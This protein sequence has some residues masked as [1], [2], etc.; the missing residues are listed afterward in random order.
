MLGKSLPFRFYL[1]TDRRLFGP[2]PIEARLETLFCALPAGTLAVQVREKDLATRDLLDLVRRIRGVAVP[3]GVPVL[4][5]DRLD[6]AIAADADGV[7]LPSSGLP[8]DRV[9]S[10]FRGLIGT[11]CHSIEEVACL[12]PS[13]VDFTTVGPVFDT[14]S[15]REYGPPLGV[16]TVR[17]A[18][19]VSRVPILAIGGVEPRTAALLRGCGVAG[20][21]AISAVWTATDPVRVITDVLDAVS[22]LAGGEGPPPGTPPGSGPRPSP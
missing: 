6:V 2:G 11:S 5:N 18:V 8:P 19:A 20:V 4:V 13:F 14:P 10:V 17:R 22:G 9:R 1:I 3:H 16:E 7:H 15:K 12:D 21:A